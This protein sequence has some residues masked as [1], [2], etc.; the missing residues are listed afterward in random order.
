VPVTKLIKKLYM[1]TNITLNLN[2]QGDF[3]T[4]FFTTYRQ[5]LWVRS[6]EFSLLVTRAAA[7]VNPD[8]AG[9]LWRYYA[10]QFR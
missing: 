2:D 4:Q 10:E 6:N 5:L 1:P 3:L 8:Q 7:K 9:R